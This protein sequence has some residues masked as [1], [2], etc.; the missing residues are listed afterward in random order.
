MIK[1]TYCCVNNNIIVSS[2]CGHVCVQTSALVEVLCKIYNVLSILDLLYDK[3]TN[4]SVI[5]ETI[6]S[7]KG[8]SEDKYAYCPVN[9][10]NVL[11]AVGPRCVDRA[12]NNNYRTT[13]R[14]EP[15]NLR[16][17]TIFYLL[18]FSRY[19][20]FMN[21]HVTHMRVLIGS[22]SSRSTI[23]DITRLMSLLIVLRVV[24]FRLSLLPYSL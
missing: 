2:S 19:C 18:W 13:Q 17:R 23:S 7:A 24:N 8:T 20:G 14:Y 3:K 10:S 9:E 16:P 12:I 1:C 5:S 11:R 15:Y 21:C 6:T 22:E 4:R